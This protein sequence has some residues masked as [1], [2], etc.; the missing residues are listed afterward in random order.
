VLLVGLPL[1]D[2]SG[3]EFVRAAK[4]ALVNCQIL[5]VAAPGT[6]EA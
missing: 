3:V 2:M 5:L 1:P 6:E 4:R